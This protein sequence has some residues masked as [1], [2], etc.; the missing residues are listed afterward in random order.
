MR[1][2]LKTDMLC[3]FAANVDASEC[4]ESELDEISSGE[5]GGERDV[6]EA[7]IPGG[8]EEHVD[9]DA[10]RNEY[11]TNRLKVCPHS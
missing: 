2:H 11:Y 4:S 8:L 9:E 7:V 3:F 5:D 6:D 10:S 1:L